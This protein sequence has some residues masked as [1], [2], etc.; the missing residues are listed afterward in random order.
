MPQDARNHD[1]PRSFAQSYRSLQQEVGAPLLWAAAVAAVVVLSAAAISLRA[2]RDVY[3]GRRAFGLSLGVGFG[4]SAITHP[5]VVFVI[6]PLWAFVYTGLARAF[7][8]FALGDEADFLVYGAAAETFAFLTETGWL[9]SAGGLGIR[10][11]AL[12]SL[13]ANAAS[14]L[15]GLLASVTTGWP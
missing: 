5:L 10:R 14:A 1:R 9:A 7:P 3:L 8:G 2:A 11:E 12:A 13:I 4:A 15:L 6:W